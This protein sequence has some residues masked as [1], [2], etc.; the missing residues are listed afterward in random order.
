MQINYTF[1]ME[2]FKLLVD[3]KSWCEGNF[4]GLSY[5]LLM[6]KMDVLD[7]KI[8]HLSGYGDPFYIGMKE[9]GITLNAKISMIFITEGTKQAVDKRF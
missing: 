1:M 6:D 3:L 8:K 5:K 9:L 4:H 2:Y 7:N